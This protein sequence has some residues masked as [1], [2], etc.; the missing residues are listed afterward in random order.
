MLACQLLQ[1]PALSQCLK[2]LLALSSVTD[3][4]LLV[5]SGQK[6]QQQPALQNQQ[7][8]QQQLRGKH[9]V[10]MVLLKVRDKHRQLSSSATIQMTGFGTLSCLFDA[11]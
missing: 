8:Q 2:N 9:T 7:Q 6:H 4:L 5:Q 3:R 11:V 1:Q 10:R